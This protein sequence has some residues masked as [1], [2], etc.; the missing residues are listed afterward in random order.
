MTPKVNPTTNNSRGSIATPLDARAE[1]KAVA[2]LEWE[3]SGL[4]TYDRLYG[5]RV[6]PAIRWAARI[7]FANLY[8]EFATGDYAPLARHGAKTEAP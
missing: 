4:P 1:V 2:G 3:L 8:R 7:D 6:N 5:C